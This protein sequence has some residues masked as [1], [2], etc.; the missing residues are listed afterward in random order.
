MLSVCCCYSKAL[1][2]SSGHRLWVRSMINGSH[3]RP[4]LYLPG[5]WLL[6]VVLYSFSS[7]HCKDILQKKNHKRKLG[8]MQS[9]LNLV[10]KRYCYS[11]ANFN[12]FY[13]YVARAFKLT[14]TIL[15]CIVNE[16]NWMKYNSDRMFSTWF[17]C[18]FLYD[19]F[20]SI[21]MIVNHPIYLIVHL[22][23]NHEPIVL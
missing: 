5:Q 17:N 12:W 23:T 20:V 18:V 10:F 11:E 19:F 8:A 21:Y 3:I 14:A 4:D 13:I 16:F 15:F 9:P 22:F 7:Q 6:P 1:H 2:H